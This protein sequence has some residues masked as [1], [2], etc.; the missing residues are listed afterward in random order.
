MARETRQG[1]WH[2]SNDALCLS[3]LTKQGPSQWSC[4]PWSTTGHC[5]FSNN[6]FPISKITKSFFNGIGPKRKTSYIPSSG[7]AELERALGWV[8]TGWC[9]EN[10]FWCQRGKSCGYD[11][12][13]RHPEKQSLGCERGPTILKLN[14]CVR[15]GSMAANTSATLWMTD[16]GYF[17]RKFTSLRGN[18]VIKYLAR[19]GAWPGGDLSLPVCKLYGCRNKVAWNRELFVNLQQRKQ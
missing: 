13:L 1:L 2:Q 5:Y 14:W 17:H 19:V 15:S 16:W 7:T 12:G 11:S 3:S 6:Y 10:T 8:K 9:C 18:N 4:H